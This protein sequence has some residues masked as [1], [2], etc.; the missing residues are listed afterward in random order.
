MSD[1][2]SP[3][4]GIWIVER[5]ILRYIVFMV[6]LRNRAFS[7]SL[8]LDMLV[9]SKSLALSTGVCDPALY[10]T[11]TNDTDILILKVVA[12]LVTSK[13]PYDSPHPGHNSTGVVSS[14]NTHENEARDDVF[15]GRPI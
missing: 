8:P 14:K 3:R 10:H 6:P 1:E 11:S 7:C 13:L 12:M 4:M 5:N 9:F 2:S 15:G